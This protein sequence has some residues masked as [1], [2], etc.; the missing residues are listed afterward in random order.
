MSA[1]TVQPAF[2]LDELRRRSPVVAE[3]WARL[4]REEPDWVFSETAGGGYCAWLPPA[5]S[6]GGLMFELVEGRRWRLVE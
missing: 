6:R 2:D 5:W 1:F 3:T 4:C